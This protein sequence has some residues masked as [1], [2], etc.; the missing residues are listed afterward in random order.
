MLHLH[1]REQCALVAAAH[2]EGFATRQAANPGC[3]QLQDITGRDYEYVL[4]DQFPCATVASRRLDGTG[5]IVEPN[6]ECSG[7]DYFSRVSP[8]GRTIASIYPP[9]VK[10]WA[11]DGS[12]S[13]LVFADENRLNG[14]DGWLPD[15][16]GVIIA[17][18]TGATDFRGVPQPPFEQRILPLD[19]SPSQP[20]RMRNDEEA[21]SPFGDQVADLQSESLSNCAQRLHYRVTS[22]PIPEPGIRS[23]AA[24]M[25]R[26]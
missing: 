18:T 23:C 1:V 24:E 21:R 5:T 26:P 4:P 20:Y 9:Y 6:A 22:L 12:G 25:L 7:P 8:D 13:R 15:G 16:S 17:L 2:P 11:T 3:S 19:G 10:L 14:V